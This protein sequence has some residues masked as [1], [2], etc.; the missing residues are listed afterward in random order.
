MKKLYVLLFSF[1]L[2]IGMDAVAQQIR[3]VKEGGVGSGNSWTDAS[4]D[5]QA[6]INNSNPGDQ[7]WV[8][9]GVYKP[10][11]RPDDIEVT[12]N[13]NDRFNSFLLKA[14][15]SVYG[16]FAG[17]E[18]EILDRDIAANETILSGNIGDENTNEDNTYHVVTIV[19]YMGPKTVFDGFIVEDGYTEAIAGSANTIRVNDQD[20]PST[21]SPGIIMY[22]VDHMELRNLIVRNNTNAALDQNAGALYMFSGAGGNLRNIQFINNKAMG[23]AGGAM[24]V[25]GLSNIPAVVNFSNVSFIGNSSSGS[26]GAVYMGQYSDLKFYDCLFENNKSGSEGGTFYLG[27]STSTANFYNTNF[28]GNQAALRGGAIRAPNSGRLNITG[29]LFENNKVLGTNAGGAIS[30]IASGLV[31]NIKGATFDSNNTPGNGGGAVYLGT[32]TYTLEDCVFTKNTCSTTGGAIFLEPNTVSPVKILN[33]TFENNVSNTTGGALYASG[34]T[35]E[36][37][38]SKFIRNRAVLSGGAMALIGTGSKTIVLNSLFFENEAQTTGGGGGAIYLYSNTTVELYN[39]SLISNKNPNS[40]L[41]GAIYAANAGAAV[42][43]YNTL[44]YGNRASTATTTLT[45]HDIYLSTSASVVSKNTITEYYGTDGVDGNI[46]GQNPLFLSTTLGDTNFLEVAAGSPAIDK[47]DINDVPAGITDILKGLDFDVLGKSRVQNGR[48][49]IGAVEHLGAKSVPTHYLIPEYTIEGTGTKTNDVLGIPAYALAGNITKWE[50]ISG[51]EKG[52]FAINPLTGEIIVV[53]ARP[54]NYELIRQFVLTIRLENDLPNTQGGPDLQ[55]LT[56]TIDLE[57]I[58]EIPEKPIVENVVYGNIVTT[59]RPKLHGIAEPN[60][61]ITIY[62]DGKAYPDATNPY[63]VNADE[64]G[65]WNF[66]FP[67][68]LALGFREFSVTSKV[69]RDAPETVQSPSV[70][71]NL[72]LFGGGTAGLKPTNVLTPNGDGKNDFWTIENLNEMYPNNEV[73]VYDKVGKIVFRQ[74]GYQGNWDG[75]SNGNP[76]PAGTY[77]YQITTGTGLDRIK[78][79]ITI[80]RGR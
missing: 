5:L 9:K 74:K 58:D 71:V 12:N 40:T 47:A 4:G 72:K 39:S 49:D 61:L 2:F 80:I 53:D 55:K 44:L 59:Y 22:F 54:L 14:E 8:A 75:T 19:N 36:L 1:S 67:E 38:S 57:N 73:M 30:A 25:Y 3:Y 41:G 68:E 35:V 56:V 29:G 64:N 31:M 21:R 37:T 26:A 20:V 11:R 65:A 63:I 69:R 50:I 6:M 70:K 24:Y 42:K 16:G 77:Y 62:V 46:V 79:A 27:S 45:R 15:V 78:G 48:M 7:V 34:V 52:A 76:L 28:I 18:D 23:G 60:S 66:R 43:M 13:A 17:T 32:G 51:N 10:N 33:C